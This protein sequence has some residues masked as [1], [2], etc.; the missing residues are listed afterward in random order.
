MLQQ[1]SSGEYA[2][3][4]DYVHREHRDPAGRDA[5]SLFSDVAHPVSPGGKRAAAA[6]PRDH[7]ST[8][9]SPL[10]MPEEWRLKI[11]EWTY[12]AVDHFDLDR[13]VASHALSYLDR[14]IAESYSQGKAV[15]SKTSFQLLAVT[16]L[17][18]A[19]KVHGTSYTAPGAGPCPQLDTFVQLSRDM[20]SPQ[21]IEETELW[22][23]DTLRWRMNPPTAAAFVSY[24]LQ[25]ALFA[26]NPRQPPGS[27]GRH[28]TLEGP[29]DDDATVRCLFD[30]SRY[31]TEMATCD[32]FLA[33][34]CRPSVT[35]LAAAL[36]ACDAIRAAGGRLPPGARWAVV[37]TATEVSGGRLRP[38]SEEVRA[39]RA[40]LEEVCSTV[41]LIE[42]HPIPVVAPERRAAA[43]AVVTPGTDARRKRRLSLVEEAAVASEEQRYSPNCVSE[44]I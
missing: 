28:R 29:C 3:A 33:L 7:G 38:N 13:D 10:G 34:N 17:Y 23:L 40:R 24:L 26:P 21:V 44:V 43:V 35:A 32:S 36:N 4:F 42:R 22:L 1:E 18:V 11:T 20:F 6:A 15:L 9:L 19:V 16:S 41:E 14:S 39:A 31:L 2:P 30:L 25:L 8:S 5:S 12:E 27:S 37:D